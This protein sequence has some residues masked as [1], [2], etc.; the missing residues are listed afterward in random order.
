VHD[1]T[2]GNAMTE[3]ALAM[4]MGFFSIMVLTAL[5]MGVAPVASKMISAAQV[6]NSETGKAETGAVA[7][8]AEDV[9]VIFAQGRF[10]DAKLQPLD[11][12]QLPA[13]KRVIMV[14]DPQLPMADVLAARARIGARD[15]VVS[16]MDDTWRKAVRGLGQ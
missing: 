9:I 15:L 5:S 1:G 14:V 7:T 6:A 4:A 16:T 13:D 2:Q 3:I 11:L 10:H 8:Q 12:A